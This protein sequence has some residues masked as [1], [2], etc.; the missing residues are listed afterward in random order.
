MRKSKPARTPTPPVGPKLKLTQV[1]AEREFRLV[2]P[3]KRAR[4][5]HL[6][7]GKPRPFPDGR[8][9][10]CVYELEG[11]APAKR[12]FFAGGVDSLQALYLAMHMAAAELV[13]SRAYQEERLTLDGDPDLG[14]PV[15]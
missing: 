9:Y 13:T 5:V 11:L 3:G 15:S 10:C 1:V 6:R 8:D 2:S 14:L 7:F 4:K 12:T